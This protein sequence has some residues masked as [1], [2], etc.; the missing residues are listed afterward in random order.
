LAN[1]SEKTVGTFPSI[2]Q[3]DLHLSALQQ[4]R[5]VAF[6]IFDRPLNQV[7]QN[8]DSDHLSHAHAR[9]ARTQIATAAADIE[10]G[11]VRLQMILQKFQSDSMHYE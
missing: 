9:E 1:A 5:I 6:D 3:L 10:N 7:R 4:L 2:S 8:V 11:R